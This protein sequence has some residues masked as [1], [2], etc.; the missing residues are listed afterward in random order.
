MLPT[1]VDLTLEHVRERSA[2]GDCPLT[3]PY[4]VEWLEDALLTLADERDALK[5]QVE[6]LSFDLDIKKIRIDHF[7]ALAAFSKPAEPAVPFADARDD[8]RFNDPV[9]YDNMNRVQVTAKHAVITITPSPAPAV[10]ITTSPI[11]QSGC[12]LNDQ[13]MVSSERDFLGY[14]GGIVVGEA[15]DLGLAGGALHHS[16]SDCASRFHPA[17]PFQGFPGTGADYVQDLNAVGICDP[18]VFTGE[19]GNLDVEWT[20]DTRRFLAAIERK[21]QPP[22]TPEEEADKLAQADAAALEFVKGMMRWELPIERLK[23]GQPMI[24]TRPG[25]GIAV[26]DT[27]YG[28][29]SREMRVYRGETID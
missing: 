8:L 20:E 6:D 3:Q 1:L 25:Y 26:T 24:P 9:A 7:E 11:F 21:K 2:Q 12:F 17:G 13:T 28:S 22:L 10:D 14:T 16:L 23:T 18:A 27:P 19:P 29:K 4:S 5:K 15:P